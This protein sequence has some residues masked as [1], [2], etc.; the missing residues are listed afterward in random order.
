MTMSKSET[1]DEVLIYIEMVLVFTVSPVSEI[2]TESF[3]QWPGVKDVK[4]LGLHIDETLTWAFHVN[5]VCRTISALLSVLRKHK[6][7]LPKQTRIQFYNAYILPHITYCL[8]IWGNCSKNQLDRIYR[9]QKNAARL[10]LDKSKTMTIADMFKYLNWQPIHDL[11]ECHKMITVFKCLND[12]LPNHLKLLFTEKPIPDRQLRSHSSHTLT[13]PFPH[14]EI[15]KKA[16]FYSGPFHWNNLSAASSVQSFKSLYLKN[17]WNHLPPQYTNVTII[18]HITTHVIITSFYS[19]I[20]SCC[21]LLH[22]Y[23]LCSLLFYIIL[24]T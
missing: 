7:F 1:R 16:L 23:Y 5:K 22:I 4:L 6:Q 11:V 8:S 2:W 10:I 3:S 20:F 15:F 21:P 19:F 24:L 18:I 13:I 9:L 14:S 12:L 17:L